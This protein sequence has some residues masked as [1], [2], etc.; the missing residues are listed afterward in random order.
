MHLE[1]KSVEH[2]SMH[3]EKHPVSI[4]YQLIWKQW[5]I[6]LPTDLETKYPVPADVKLVGFGH[7]SADTDPDNGDNFLL[8]L[9]FSFSQ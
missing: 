8:D 2:G 6:P 5:L 3:I 9:C 4:H 7:M 1:H